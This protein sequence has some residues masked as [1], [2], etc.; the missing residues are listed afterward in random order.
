MEF[1]A[2][3]P[4]VDVVTLRLDP[5]AGVIPI[6]PVEIKEGVETEVG[7]TT[8]VKVAVSVENVASV[9]PPINPPVPTIAN[10]PGVRFDAVTVGAEIDVESVNAPVASGA[11]ETPLNVTT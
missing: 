11:P 2:N 4:V 9:S 1:T 8:L 7:A 6:A 3:V 5:A 10:C